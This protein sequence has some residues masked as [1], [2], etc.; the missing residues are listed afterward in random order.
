MDFE[1]ALRRMASL[2][3]PDGRL[4]VV[5]LAEYTPW[6]WVLGGLSGIPHRLMA[7]RR[8]F[9]RHPAP[10]AAATLTLRQIR[11]VARRVVP[12]ARVRRRLYWR[13]SIEWTHR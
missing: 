3:A 13:Y 7:R 9:Y 12:G 2:V 8:G 4:V 11:R 10:V 5:G 1:P 6:S